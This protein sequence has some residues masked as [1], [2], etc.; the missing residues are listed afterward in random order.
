[1]KIL[2]ELNLYLKSYENENEDSDWDSDEECQAVLIAKDLKNTIEE[3]SSLTIE[4]NEVEKSLM[5]ANSNSSKERTYSVPNNSMDQ[6]LNTSPSINKG[7]SFSSM[8]S[9]LSKDSTAQIPSLQLK[10]KSL[11]KNVLKKGTDSPHKEVEHDKGSSLVIQNF[12]DSLNDQSLDDDSPSTPKLS[13][14]KALQ[15]PVH[16][17]RA[18]IRSNYN[19]RS[20]SIHSYRSNKNTAISK[21]LKKKKKTNEKLGGIKIGTRQ[22]DGSESSDSFSST[23]NSPKSATFA[24][25][26]GI[27]SN[28]FS[29]T[30]P[31]L[32]NR[33]S[34]FANKSLLKKGKAKKK[35]KKSFKTKRDYLKKFSKNKMEEMKAIYDQKPSQVAERPPVPAK[36][37]SINPVVLRAKESFKK[38]KPMSM[39]VDFKEGIKD[40]TKT[41]SS[42][43]NILGV[44]AIAE[45]RRNSYRNIKRNSDMNQVTRLVSVFNSLGGDEIKTKR[46]SRRSSNFLTARN[47]SSRFLEPFGGAEPRMYK[48][49]KHSKK[50]K[51]KELY[52]KNRSR[53]LIV[54]D[55]ARER[56]RIVRRTLSDFHDL[57][58][59]RNNISIELFTGE[60]MFKE[61]RVRKQTDGT[62]LEDT[63]E[64]CSSVS[65]NSST[66]KCNL[67]LKLLHIDSEESSECEHLVRFYSLPIL[68]SEKECLEIR[69]EEGDM[70]KAYKSNY[71]KTTIDDF[72][73]LRA[74]SHGAYGK[75]CLARKKQTRD[76]FAIKIMDKVKMEEKGVTEMVMNE[77]DILNKIDNDYVVRGVYTF[78]TKKYLYIVM[79]YMKGGDFANLL[80]G[81]G[82]FEEDAAR[83]YLAQIVI[84]VDYLHNLGIIHR[85]LKP[86]NILVDGEG[87]IKLTDFG[88]SEINMKNMKQKYQDALNK[89]NN[90]LF[91]DDSDDSDDSDSP[92]N[93]KKLD[94]FQLS[95]MSSEDKRE[96][97]H[98][99]KL[100]LKQDL[101]K[102][103]N[104]NLAYN[105]IKKPKKVLGTPDYIAPEV[106][107]G[108]EVTRAVDWWAVGV[109]A[110]EFL[111]GWLPF[112][113]DSPE[114][115][116]ENIKN[117]KIKAEDKLDQALSKP[118]K[119]LVFAFMD[120]N[121]EK[122]LGINGIEEIK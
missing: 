103:T 15:E 22:R 9:A 26:A 81:I 24:K 25:V 56:D 13:Q 109:I 118:A 94:R 33:L 16:H 30:D 32:A 49:R 44:K 36:K 88:L 43:K 42:S 21:K 119:D 111:T 72:N 46:R 40:T 11:Y 7:L 48:S 59:T 121:P 66:S 3:K 117:R 115:I 29:D 112:N 38:V 80:E 2:K 71:K 23:T 57:V 85:D 114:K 95:K 107:L 86:D 47:E 101:R 31:K 70:A 96:I 4:L 104:T 98:G 5:A 64:R 35:V 84:A 17:R 110:F 12:S 41:S 6:G 69:S 77:R 102:I 63:V 79:E 10:D 82:A 61:K 76:L 8:E 62:S 18:S 87:M 55:V 58:L 20:S 45:D 99:N 50:F 90:P 83:F 74:V 93:L 68:P 34:Q 78:Q 105:P 91:V 120:Y 54:K 106:I 97:A 116:F 1:M 113:D 37:S 28:K 19:Q 60:K 100:K 67:K 39:A 27:Q 108:K 14:N 92:V 73:L 52:A 122:R 51:L 89:S 65:G 75:V 53:S